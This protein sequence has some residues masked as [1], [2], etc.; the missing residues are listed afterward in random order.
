MLVKK[1]QLVLFAEIHLFELQL[2]H[3]LTKLLHHP[4]HLELAISLLDGH[5]QVFFVVLLVMLVDCETLHLYNIDE[6]AQHLFE[7]GE[8]GKVRHYAENT[9]AYA[10]F[11]LTSCIYHLI[12][13]LL[14]RFLVESALVAL[15]FYLRV[16]YRHF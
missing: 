10:Y 11:K 15:T 12:Y 14:R 7:E 8:E 6:A 5:P 1:S 13:R 3:T 9:L 16:R 4:F 2:T